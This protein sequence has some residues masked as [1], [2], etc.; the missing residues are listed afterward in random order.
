ML[1]IF[2]AYFVDLKCELI[3]KRARV[4]CINTFGYKII[5]SPARSF[6]SCTKGDH[7]YHVLFPRRWLLPRHG[8][9]GGK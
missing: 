1:K 9:H 3:E 2:I 4:F 5:K 7:K 6:Y 8:Y